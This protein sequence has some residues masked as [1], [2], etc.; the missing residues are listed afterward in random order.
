MDGPQLT[1]PSNR[2][3]QVDM[4]FEK[5]KLLG[6][7]DFVSDSQPGSDVSATSGVGSPKNGIASVGTGTKPD[8]PRYITSAAPVPT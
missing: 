5:Y 2:C 3:T 6:G 7:K 8:K 4:K 1:L